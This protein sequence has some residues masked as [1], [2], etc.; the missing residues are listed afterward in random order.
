MRSMKRTTRFI[1]SILDTGVATPVSAAPLS[2]A[3]LALTY[4][5]NS[6]V[7]LGRPDSMNTQ[8]Y[9]FPAPAGTPVGIGTGLGIGRANSAGLAQDPST[10]TLYGL[11]PNNAAEAVL[12]QIDPVTG[13]ATAVPSTVPN[14][15]ADGLAFN[16]SGQGVAADSLDP[17][18]NGHYSRFDVDPITGAVTNPALIDIDPNG[19]GYYGYANLA[20]DSAGRLW[21]LTSFGALYQLD[22][23]EPGGVTSPIFLTDANGTPLDSGE[24]RGLAI[25]PAFLNVPEPSSL[26]VCGCVSLLGSVC[27]RRVRRAP[28]E[29]G[30]VSLK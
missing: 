13:L 29:Y 11:I 21:L 18:G 1:R 30:T 10:G 16:T 22:P 15:Y 14:P 19:D 4:S 3:P 20:F 24:W 5:G 6:L 27:Y 26:L 9:S 8:L 12:Y 7:A 2:F 28:P 25:E 23:T 17:L